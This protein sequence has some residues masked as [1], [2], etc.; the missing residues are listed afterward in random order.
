MYALGS[1]AVA[2]GAA[3]TS[4]P[5]RTSAPPRPGRVRLR[6][7]QRRRRQARPCRR[8][9]PLACRTRRPCPRGPPAARLLRE[10]RRDRPLVV[11]AEQDERRPHDRREVD[12]LVERAFGGRAVAEEDEGDPIARRAVASPTQTRRHAAPGSRS[13]RRS[14]RRRS[15]AG[16]HQPA[17]C[18]RH[19]DSTV[20]AGD[21]AE[22]ADRRL[23]VAR[24][25]PVALLERVDGA[26]LDRL[27]TPVDGI[28]A[29]PPLAVV[30]DRPLVVRP[31]QHERA[32]ESKQ[33]VVAEIARSR[34]AQPRPR[35]RRT[36]ATRRRA[37]S[38]A[39]WKQF[40]HYRARPFLMVSGTWRARS[41]ARPS[42]CCAPSSRSGHA[43]VR[44][45]DRASHRGD[46]AIG[47]AL[48]RPST[49]R[50][51]ARIA[52]RH[53]A[54]DAAAGGARARALGR[55]R[56]TA[57]QE[58][59]HLP[60]HRADPDGRRVE[61]GRTRGERRRRSAARATR[62][63]GRRH[64]EAALRADANDYAQLDRAIELLHGHLGERPLVMRADALFHRALVRACH[65]RQLEGGDARHRE[66]ARSDPGRVLGRHRARPAD[67]GRPRAATR[68]DARGTTRPRSTSSSTSTSACSRSRSRRRSATRGTSSSV[69][70][71]RPVAYGPVAA[72]GTTGP[73]RPSSR[74]SQTSWSWY[75]RMFSVCPARY[76]RTCF[77]G[78][79]AATSASS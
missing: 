32:V 79:T 59:R 16:F 25:D 71:C 49:R 50:I 44:G 33:L 74:E 3:C 68:R 19:Q 67:P 60:R 54:T 37:P 43:D 53:L 29:D 31:Q 47:P 57:R 62:A 2:C 76:Q 4:P 65:N 11:V 75:A 35:S 20:D 34:R 6:R 70:D 45:C 21:A 39:E 52:A 24:K 73:P 66:G 15:S 7:E 30:D 1:S 18:P 77:G 63:R 61:C 51:R 56:R 36:E 72:P 28:R 22:Q 40:F 78:G 10:R 27:V 69:E 42:A 9:A 17:G 13:G 14:T 23:A 12:P 41:R 26:G 46:R 5:R 58:R 48:G 8:L 55:G 64:A 38:S